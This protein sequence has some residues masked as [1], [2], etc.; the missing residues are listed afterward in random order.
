MN[1]IAKVIIIHKD[2]T[3]KYIEGEMASKWNQACIGSTTFCYSHDQD[4]FKD[5]KWTEGP[6]TEP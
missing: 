4:Y 6:K 5:I 3:S 2:G 1:E